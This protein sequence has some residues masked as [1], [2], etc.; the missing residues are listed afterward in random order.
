[1][2]TILEKFDQLS[3]K[4]SL[5]LSLGIMILLFL[6]ILVFVVQNR[7]SITSKAA[8][9]APT[10]TPFVKAYGP[11]PT[12]APTIAAVRPWIG[13]PGD[14]III[15]GKNFGMNPPDSRLAIGGVVLNENDIVDW[16]DTRIEAVIPQ[17]A[18]SGSPLQIRIGTYPIV[19]SLPLVFY[20]PDTSF[21]LYKTGATVT[22][23][24]FSGPLT[25]TSWTSVNGAPAQKKTATYTD[26]PGTQPILTLVPTETLLSLILEDSSGTVI[27]YVVDPIQ[28]GF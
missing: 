26:K 13:K 15:E 28:F 27:P 22:A 4:T 14:T 19:E 5:V 8:V 21:R 12:A 16:M 20:T 2:E 24:P 11:L 10:P 3:Y 1:M 9:V 23:D 17:G 6:P 25:V 7:T 18:P